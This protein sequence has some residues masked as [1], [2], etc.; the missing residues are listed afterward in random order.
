MKKVYIIIFITFFTFLSAQQDP[1][2]FSTYINPYSNIEN[3]VSLTNEEIW[4]A[5]D[6]DIPIGFSF[7]YFGENYDTIYMHGSI[8]T[9]VL[10]NFAENYVGISS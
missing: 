9:P 2:T 4:Y 1:Y 6:R 10:L 7:S 8:A 3:D 5:I